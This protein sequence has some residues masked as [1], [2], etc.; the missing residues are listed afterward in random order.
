MYQIADKGIFNAYRKIKFSFPLAVSIFL[1][2]LGGW[3]IYVSLSKPALDL[4]TITLMLFLFTSGIS[5]LLK[6]IKYYIDYLSNFTMQIGI[7]KDGL[8]F[9]TADGKKHKVPF[10]DFLDASVEVSLISNHLVLRSRYFRNVSE[11]LK[12]GY[13]YIVENKFIRTQNREISEV[14]ITILRFGGFFERPVKSYCTFIVDLKTI[15][16]LNKLDEF[17]EN[18]KESWEKWMAENNIDEK[19]IDEKVALLAKKRI[20]KVR[21]FELFL[22]LISVPST[23]WASYDYYLQHPSRA[24]M[25]FVMCGFLIIVFISGIIWLDQVTREKFRKIGIS[26]KNKNREEDVNEISNSRFR[27]P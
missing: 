26:L 2:G 24:L 9:V 1:M 5:I 23:I 8:I 4:L 17:I 21:L 10:S 18:W 20:F 13:E 25:D 19:L 12:R 11:L 3:G 14:G 22:G 27:L 6:D 7:E 15:G 16:G